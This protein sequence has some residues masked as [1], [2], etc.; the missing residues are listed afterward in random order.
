[1]VIHPVSPTESASIEYTGYSR[2]YLLNRVYLNTY[3]GRHYLH[4]L[5]KNYE[6]LFSRAEKLI[7]WRYKHHGC[8]VQVY[9]CDSVRHPQIYTIKTT[10]QVKSDNS[11][12]G[13]CSQGIHLTSRKN[14]TECLQDDRIP[15]WK[16]LFFRAYWLNAK[17]TLASFNS[18]LVKS[19]ASFHMTFTRA[20]SELNIKL[21]TQTLTCA[22]GPEYRK[23]AR[24]LQVGVRSLTNA[25]TAHD[26]QNFGRVNKTVWFM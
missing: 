11:K 23:Q 14:C 10:K 18:A 15:R 13:Y 7:N 12:C 5:Q 25:V 20:V 2:D 4:D 8:T 26:T 1:M 9:I 6:C 3:D 21:I 16:I 22:S 24:C 17:I 19:F